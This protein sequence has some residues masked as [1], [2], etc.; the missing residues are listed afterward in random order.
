MKVKTSFIV[1]LFLSAILAGCSNGKL[2]DFDYGKIKNGKYVNSFFG[3]E[4]SIPENWFI[5]SQ[6]NLDA[7]IKASGEVAAGDNKELQA[8][9]KTTEI[10]SANLLFVS[11][12]EVGSVALNPYIALVAENVKI[13]GIFIKN[14]KEYL[15]RTAKLCEQSQIPYQIIG[16][17][18]TETINNQE[19]AVMHIMLHDFAYQ[20]T[21]VIY[22]KDFAIVFT[23]T[24]FDD[25]QKE[26]LEEIM[27]SV[28]FK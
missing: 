25:E 14:S 8:S 26:V 18:T 1:L 15:Q 3:M 27:N 11:E 19:F 5:M 10:N 12:Y 24:Y 6:E 13:S 17:I 22:K 4:M 23:L 21:Y 2:K 20:K 9:V 28:K 16:D 7:L